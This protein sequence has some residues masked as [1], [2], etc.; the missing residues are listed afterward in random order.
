MATAVLLKLAPSLTPPPQLGRHRQEKEGREEERTEIGNTSYSKPPP[1]SLGGHQTELCLRKGLW[2]RM[3]GRSI[4]APAPA[5]CQEV[6]H[7]NITACPPRLPAFGR[8]APTTMLCIPH[9]AVSL[10]ESRG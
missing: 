1:A 9:R 7:T 3:E 5:S 10:G 6:G 2:E 8:E 4:R